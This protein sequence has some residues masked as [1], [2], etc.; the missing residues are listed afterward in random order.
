MLALLW[1]GAVWTG[2]LFLSKSSSVGIRFL[3]NGPEKS[4]V[5]EAFDG[6]KQPFSLAAWAH[7]RDLLVEVPLSGGSTTM[8][9]IFIY[10]DSREAVF[11]ELKSGVWKG[12]FDEGGCMLS[13]GAAYRLFGSSNVVGMKVVC[14]GREWII[15]GIVNKKSP[16]I[17]LP[18]DENDLL[19]FMELNYHE[20][21]NPVAL[22]EE[23]LGL[24]GLAGEY[25]LF[26]WPLL[27][28]AV[29][30][31]FF[32]PVWVLGI[33]FFCRW[34]VK[35]KWIFAAAA[36]TIGALLTLRFPQDWIPTRWS[37]FSF[38]ARK[39]EYLGDMMKNLWQAR[40]YDGDLKLA[41]YFFTTAA[42]SLSASACALAGLLFTLCSPPR[43]TERR[44]GK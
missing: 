17:M 38:W 41:N 39:F 15:R 9:G 32:L 22:A 12:A 23:F 5:E 21:E 7:K 10:G 28:A 30:V 20:A 6:K 4:R 37:D 11:D 26:D 33:A 43:R 42:L 27:K 8:D 14:R 34:K 29:R 24:N 31:L 25:L 2:M 35:N 36:V 3:E 13:E 1:A 16:W 40:L 18:A 44:S 19:P